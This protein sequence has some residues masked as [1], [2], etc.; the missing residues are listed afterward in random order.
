MNSGKIIS[1]GDKGNINI[2]SSSITNSGN[3]AAQK[4]LNIKTLSLLNDKSGII[5]S[6]G[7]TTIYSDNLTN[8]GLFHSNGNINF[9]NNTTTESSITNYGTIEAIKNITFGKEDSKIGSIK[10]IGGKILAVENVTIYSENFENSSLKN[11]EIEYVNYNE[12]LSLK[13][14]VINVVN[15]GYY[16]LSLLGEI[17]LP[18]S[19]EEIKKINEKLKTKYTE[20]IENLKKKY[21]DKTFI[22]T[23]IEVG[24]YSEKKAVNFGEV[25]IERILSI[26]DTYIDE[27]F[28]NKI[29]KSKYYSF[30]L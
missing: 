17:N 25:K 4:N 1:I 28:I 2:T 8:S 19:T 30:F 18:I 14:G 5:E 10:N 27:N 24:D 7:D 6:G 29:L 3:I 13:S 22:V 11:I 12:D 23:G 16:A 20:I 15:I 26:K 9:Y 21:P